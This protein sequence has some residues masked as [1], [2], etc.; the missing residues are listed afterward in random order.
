MPVQQVRPRQSQPERRSQSE[1]RGEAETALLDAA[2]RLFARQG[3]EATSLAAIGEEAGYSRGLANHHFG[4]RAALIERLARRGQRR[5]ARG[6]EHL[7]APTVETL[8]AVADTYLA[9][10][11]DPNDDVRAFFVMRG[12][13][14]PLDSPLRP[15]YAA[16]D[17]R[18]RAGIERV[19]QRGQEAGTIRA[20]ADPHAFA[21]VL[22]G[23]LRGVGS[24]CLMDAEAVDLDAVRATTR[25]LI[26][27]SLAPTNGTKN[28]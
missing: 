27:S 15:V 3:I 11:D 28:P 9:L 4:T 22:V 18:F 21:T 1:R 7:E 10:F 17:K 20:E 13:S 24:Q 19:I 25:N 23:L 6:V 2:M 12:G 14:I 16:D 5:F 26:E 8:V